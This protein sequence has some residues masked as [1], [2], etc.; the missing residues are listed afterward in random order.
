MRPEGA[1]DS[2]RDPEDA[3]EDFFAS[4]VDEV[5]LFLD[6][7]DKTPTSREEIFP[8]DEVDETPTS[9]DEES[10]CSS[11]GVVSES[12]RIVEAGAPAEFRYQS[13]KRT[14]VELY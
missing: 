10:P 2:K 7:V 1:L 8:V 12:D 3:V 9:G 6:V 13:V 11:E 14:A 4:E 5:F